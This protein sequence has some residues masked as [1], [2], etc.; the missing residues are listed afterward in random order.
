MG[1][2]DGTVTL[3]LP[4]VQNTYGI[5]FGLHVGIPKNA[6]GGA[7]HEVENLRVFNEGIKRFVVDERLDTW[8]NWDIDGK[9]PMVWTV[10]SERSRAAINLAAQQG[11]ERLWFVE[12]EPDPNG[13]QSKSTPEE[14]AYAAKEWHGKIRWAGFGQL[15]NYRQTDWIDWLE[16]YF[17]AGGPVPDA[18][19]IHS[20]SDFPQTW[21]LQVR[22]FKS[23]AVDTN[24]ERPIFISECGGW[25]RNPPDEQKAI[26]VEIIDTLLRGEIAAAFWFSNLYM[27]WKSGDLLFKNNQ[28]NYDLS[29]IGEFLLNERARLRKPP[30]VEPPEGHTIYLPN[31]SG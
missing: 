9:V 11:D 29:M 8:Y 12:N 28:G 20:Y 23:W 4:P 30:H 27:Y 7:E 10:T 1:N 24:N 18:W 26:M 21:I 3:E 22:Q 15:V 5:P 31:V 17:R 19:H 14:V 16:T 6:Y 2:R 25:P 13:G